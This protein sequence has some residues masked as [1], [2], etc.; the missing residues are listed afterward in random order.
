MLKGLLRHMAGLIGL[1]LIILILYWGIGRDLHRLPSPLIGKP[2]PRFHLTRLRFPKQSL[3]QNIFPG[4]VTL[5][6]VWASWCSSCLAEQNTWRRITAHESVFIVGLNYK[7]KRATALTW[8]KRYGTVHRI[9][10]FD[11]KGAFALNLGVYG[12]PELFLIDAK[13]IIR[14]KHIGPMDL[15][16]WKKIIWPQLQSLS[17]ST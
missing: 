6:R 8:L 9:D 17:G 16:T 15:V 1:V 3:D 2:V 5:L 13:G 11:P 10:L 14:Y 7:D 4:H 12:T